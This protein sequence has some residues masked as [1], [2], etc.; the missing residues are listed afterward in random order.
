MTV[1]AVF[2][3]CLA[4]AFSGCGGGGGSSNTS[5][6]T[7]P[8]VLATDPADNT[9]GVAVNLTRVSATFSEEMDAST[10]SDATFMLD[11]GATGTASYDA[12]SKTAVFTL[13]GELEYNKT[14]TAAITTEAKDLAGN[15][16]PGS[17][18]WSFT[19]GSAPAPSVPANL[20]ATGSLG[21]IHL[22]WDASTGANLAG[23]NIYKSTDGAVF[24]ELNGAP[25]TGTSYDDAIA[26]P[27]GD[28]VFYYYRVT[29][30]G[31]AE[32]SPSDTVR[33]IHGNRLDSSL[34]S[35][36]TT[37]SDLSPYIVEG[38]VSSEGSV[39][40]AAGTKL[41]VL[42]N[43]SLDILQGNALVVN[44][45]FRILSSTAATATLTSHATGT[46]LDANQGFKIT[47]N[48]CV[49]YGS[50]GDG[51][52]FQNAQI[53]NL[54]SGASMEIDNC[55]PKFYNLYI[56]ANSDSTSSRISLQSSSGVVIQNCSIT[57]LVPQISGD[58]RAAG[59]QMDHNIIAPGPYNYVLD[60]I[61]ASAG[62]VDAGQIAYNVFDGSG[63]LDLSAQ[64]G[65]TIP[66]GNNYWKQGE[67]TIRYQNSS[68]SIVDFTPALDSAPADAG[69][70]W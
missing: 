55:K 41:Y 22:S 50:G 43:G 69:P 37:T 36:I 67:P 68:T 8:T 7:H 25:I 40:V 3:L 9:T 63:L 27:D 44:G 51:T 11:G 31:D 38:S 58:H 62:P 18:A 10:I 5:E 30:A 13:S 28:G 65:G 64:T 15:G 39:N 2:M 6:T 33:S 45:L 35:G 32:S 1:L 48:S 54:Q 21:N 57:G 47:I 17:H 70:T 61:A 12:A 23:Y 16:L 19:T 26:S 4:V 56:T 53:L 59:L 46:A 24:S 42:D 52:L 34:A 60:F 14:Y 66:L 20:L 29:A 49:D